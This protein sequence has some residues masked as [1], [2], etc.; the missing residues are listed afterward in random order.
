MNNCN[1]VSILH[2]FEDIPTLKFRVIRLISLIS[3][4]SLAPNS[5]GFYSGIYVTTMCD[6]V[7]VGLTVSEKSPGQTNKQTR[8]P[9][10]KGDS[11]T[12]ISIKKSFTHI[13][14]KFTTKK[15]VAWGPHNPCD[16]TMVKVF[17]RK[18]CGFDNY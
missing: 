8:E 11:C 18:M 15:I 6:M 14:K 7:T 1:Y 17:S 9:L 4:D 2:H 12:R 5:I 13:I 16:V 3:I 10:G